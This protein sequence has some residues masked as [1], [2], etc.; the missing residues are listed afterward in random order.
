M[1]KN[2]NII[3]DRN[4]VEDDFD[5]SDIMG[6]HY[7]EDDHDGIM[8]DVMSGLIEASSSQMILA[9]ELTKLAVEK[10]TAKDINEDKVFAIFKKS[11]AV[12]AESYPLQGLLEKSELND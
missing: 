12:I 6:S 8:A 2:T 5:L 3:K 10:S 1:A 11:A 9:M 4:P 7:D